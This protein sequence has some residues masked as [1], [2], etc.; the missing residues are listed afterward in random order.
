MRSYKKIAT[1]ALILHAFFSFLAY[2]AVIYG[3]N[4]MAQTGKYEPHQ[5]V[6]GVLIGGGII[7]FP[8]F[9]IAVLLSLFS[10]GTLV[11]LGLLFLF[12]LG[13]TESNIFLTTL[14]PLA[15]T[16]LLI[17]KFFRKQ[18]KGTDRNSMEK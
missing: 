14:Y 5:I 17:W 18:I 12:L 7:M 3:L 1:R 13:V 9:A 6:M 11:L 16:C 4:I 10:W 15:T 8:L 2:I